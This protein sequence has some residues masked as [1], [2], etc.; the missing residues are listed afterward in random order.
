MKAEY[1]R[2]FKMILKAFPLLKRWEIDQL[3]KRYRQG[4]V[5]K[6]VGDGVIYT[7]DP[8]KLLGCG[9]AKY[10]SYSPS[11]PFYKHLPSW[12]CQDYVGMVYFSNGDKK[13]WTYNGVEFECPYYLT[14]AFVISDGGKHRYFPSYGDYYFDLPKKQPTIIMP[15]DCPPPTIHL[16]FGLLCERTDGK[17]GYLAIFADAIPSQDGDCFKEWNKRYAEWDDVDY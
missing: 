5:D 7:N 6:E 15:I 1:V 4:V 11:A 13:H 17:D 10:S 16:D 12:I 2:D 3:K 9:T 14:R 8:V